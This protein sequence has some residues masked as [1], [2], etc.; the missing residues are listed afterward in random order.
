MAFLVNKRLERS[1]ASYEPINGR[2]IRI[3]LSAKPMDINIIQVYMPTSDSA[4]G[5]VDDIYGVIEDE[6]RKTPC[7]EPVFVI[8]DFNAKVGVT[9]GAQATLVTP[10]SEGHSPG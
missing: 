7:K 8:G 3:R 4:D 9:T 6:L 10:S 5:E 2:M 1:I